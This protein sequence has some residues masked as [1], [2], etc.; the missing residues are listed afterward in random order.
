[1]TPP[2]IAL[3]DIWAC[4]VCW[5]RFEGS[6]DDIRARIMRRLIQAEHVT[7]VREDSSAV[8]Q[9]ADADCS[10]KLKR[11]ANATQHIMDAHVT[12]RYQ[13]AG[14]DF[15]SSRPSNVKVRIGNKHQKK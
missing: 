5:K 13:C 12:L 15:S 4:M 6:A 9:C 3:N 2:K 7:E 11:K 14:C 1:M 10:K 8:H